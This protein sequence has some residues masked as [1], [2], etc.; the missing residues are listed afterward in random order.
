MAY[1]SKQMSFV[2]ENTFGE[3]INSQIHIYIEQLGISYPAE[4]NYPSII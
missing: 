3:L 1:E 2:I 4:C